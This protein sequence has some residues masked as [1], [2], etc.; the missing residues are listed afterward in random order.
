MLSGKVAVITGG[1][2]GIGKSIALRL[3]QNHASV[4]VIYAGNASLAGDV[5]TLVRAFGVKAESYQC[6]V[7]NFAAC[8]E[9]ISRIV[10]DF[11][12]IDI[13]VNNAGIT[14]DSLIFSMKEESWDSV[15]T[16][17]LKGVFNMIKHVS[18]ILLKQHSGKII[19]ISSVSGLT[20]NAGQVNYSAS[21]AGVIGLTKSVA[22]ELAAKGICCNAIAPGLIDTEMT[23]DLPGRDKLIWN[24]PM[25]KA[26]S[27]EDVAGVVLF[28]A[29]SMS[30][31]VTGE[32]IRVDGGLAM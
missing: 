25:K 18:P 10:Q 28:L 31:Y 27:P 15:L 12:H 4:A 5:C 21:K 3:A 11:G 16:T 22:R 6:D 20:G 29:G 7:G 8:K 13:L 30:D 14:K 2:R 19:N 17:N 23:F 26:G 1:S 24:V 9:T 32:V